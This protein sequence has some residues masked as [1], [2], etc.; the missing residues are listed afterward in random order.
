[1]AKD[2]KKSEK[3]PDRQP[4]RKE[5]SAR[6]DE[7]QVEPMKRAH[8]MAN[9]VLQ[10][11]L[12][13][14][15]FGV[16][17]YLNFR[18]HKRWDLSEN[19]KY[20][21][22]AETAG[23]LASMDKE[24]RVTMAF[25]SNSKIHQNLKAL[26]EEYRLL[27]KGKIR[28]DVIDPA[29]DRSEAMKIS[30]KYKLLLETSTV[31]IEVDGRHKLVTEDEMI[32]DEGRLF[33]GEDAITSALIAATESGQKTL[34]V[35][36][37]HGP[38]R[39]I[40]G[41]TALSELLELSKLQFFN[42]VPLSLAEIA[43][44]PKD[45]DALM[46]LGATLDFSEREIGMI[47]QFWERDN[48]A[49]FVMLAPEGGNV[50]TPNLRKFLSGYGIT[51]QPDRV[52]EVTDAGIRRF[53]VQGKFLEG[54]KING[55]Q[56]G[57][58]TTF[59]GQTCSLKVLE[60]NMELTKRGLGIIALVQSSGRFWG[61]Y[62]YTGES[63]TLDATDNKGPVFLAAT[64][65]KG[66]TEDLKIKLDTSRMVV[67]GNGNL[68]DPDYLTDSNVNF[69]LSGLNWLLDREQLIDILPKTA[70]AYRIEIT[71]EQHD[72]MFN[73]AIF[74]LPGIVFAIGLM[75]WSIRRA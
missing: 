35:I 7:I 40:D 43:E 47:Q 26:L 1:M 70:T 53:D 23:F 52:L 10:I 58:N 67:V 6:M 29:R 41:K 56:K 36:T 14:V 68:L 17:S 61:E 4:R 3:I 46:L 32:L 24:V 71:E 51:P 66:A 65:E 2:E 38:L 9:V 28:L 39:E 16:V 44:I 60:D 37:G 27:S 59:Y 54:S 45:A 72:R 50:R 42:V 18:H 5:S 63:P 49:L 22:S 62:N 25:L 13:L 11:V 8:I 55:A 73:L 34:Y 64:V 12:V 69:V 75:V 31:I 74:V 48:G 19:Q 21:V 30:Q 57:S 33:R 20:T 15:L